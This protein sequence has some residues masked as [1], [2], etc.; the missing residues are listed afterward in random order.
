MGDE[1]F[2]KITEYDVDGNGEDAYYDTETFTSYSFC[3]ETADE[4]LLH[5]INKLNKQKNSLETILDTIKNK[6]K[7]NTTITREEFEDIIKCQTMN[8]KE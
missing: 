2:I 7:N 1:W 5:D 4:R 3:D 6:F 8:W